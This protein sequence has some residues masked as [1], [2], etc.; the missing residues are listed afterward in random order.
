MRI[1]IDASRLAVGH[2]TGTEN[3]A[4][5]VTRGLLRSGAGKHQFT[6][7]S[8]RALPAEVLEELD[9]QFDTQFLALPFPR[10]WT[11]VRLSAE[12]FWR[13]PSVLFVPAHVVPLKHPSR[14]V[15]TI[16]DLGYLYFPQAHTPRQRYYLDLSTRFSA[17]AAATV[18]AISQATKNDL[19]R[20]YNILPEKIRVIYHGYD[21]NFFRPTYDT[22]KFL[23]ARMRYQIG[24]GPYLL[25][26]GTIQPRK[27]LARLIEAFAHLV[28]DSA[29]AYPEREK[30]QLVL[31]GQRGWLSEP[32]VELV[33]K[34]KLGNRVIFTGYIADEDLPVL[35][36]G[37]TAFVLP[38]LYEGFGMGVL[39]AMACGCPVVCS[40][41]ASL[42]EV[43]GEAALLHHPLD[44][45]ALEAQLRRLL[46]NPDLQK[47]L[48]RKGFEQ[49][50][51][52]SWEKCAAET[53]E[54]LEKS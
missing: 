40:N 48:R 18:I 17:Q 31:G 28:N 13:P 41:A 50:E 25:Y 19:V 21:K 6:L 45:A 47:E 38:S 42:P 36:S 23:A 52:F 51:K 1:G 15:V 37:A 35:L 24:A 43:A 26:V 22:E 29:F 4:L 10:F 34:L 11:H 7:Y 33:E 8:N 49:V 44:Q 9:P 32:I 46:T 27:N 14:T 53:L 12:M 39:E 3:Y 16:H 5:Q 20:H 30:L 54:V 2:R